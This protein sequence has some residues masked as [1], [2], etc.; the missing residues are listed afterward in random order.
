[1][2]RSKLGAQ[3]EFERALDA[4]ELVLHFQPKVHLVSG[5]VSGVEALVRW[6]HPERGLLP[7]SQFL[8]LIAGTPIEERMSWWTLDSALTHLEEWHRMGLTLEVSVNI[9]GRH[10]LAPGFAAGLRQR[11]AGR[12]L[13]LARHLQIEML[14]TSALEDVAAA[15][16][17]IRECQSLGVRFALDDFGTGYSSLVYLRNLPAD[18]IK[19]DQTFVRDMLE[20]AAVQTLVAGVIA[21]SKTYE[22]EVVAEGV[23]TEAHQD[24]LVSM[25]CEFGQGFGIARPM[26]AGEVADRCAARRLEPM[27]RAGEWA[28]AVLRERAA[29]Q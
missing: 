12:A 4:G 23:E 3:Q 17:V 2:S 19:I 13:P 22:R 21:L 9:A 8:P 25:G 14:E 24:L 27:R 1:M 7:P 29:T 16:R 15:G 10:L 11:L 20:D 5:R 28:Q 26:P 18:V 6:Q